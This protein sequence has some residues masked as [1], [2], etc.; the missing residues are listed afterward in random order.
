MYTLCQSYPFKIYTEQFLLNLA[1]YTYG[2]REVEC[3]G[4]QLDQDL[5]PLINTNILFS[6]GVAVSIS[7]EWSSLWGGIDMVIFNVSKSKPSRT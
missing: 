2:P 1:E 6:T 4:S 3:H 5:V 7:L